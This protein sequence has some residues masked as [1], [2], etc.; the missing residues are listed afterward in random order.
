[1][2]S[3]NLS[4][5]GSSCLTVADVTTCLAQTVAPTKQAVTRKVHVF[6]W[7]WLRVSS[8]T[9]R[10]KT[11]YTKRL[12]ICGVPSSHSLF[13]AVVDVVLMVH[14]GSERRNKQFICILPDPLQ[15]RS[16]TN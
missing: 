8:I 5:C 7:R 10:L 13:L 4:D 11:K 9:V 1:M 2:H 6:F 3:C 16:A 15:G 12:R 14:Y